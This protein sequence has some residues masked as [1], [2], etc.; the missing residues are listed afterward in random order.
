[1]FLLL[2]YLIAIMDIADKRFKILVKPNSRENKIESFDNQRNAYRI[3]IKAKPEGNK[4]N[5]EVI[6]FLSK[7]L[8][9]RVKI[10]AGFKS[11]EKI[12]EIR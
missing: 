12:V 11:R 6:K 8:K 5:I 7:L 3:S 4:A 9:K 10:V 1:M 2:M